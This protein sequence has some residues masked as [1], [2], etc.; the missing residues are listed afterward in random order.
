MKAEDLI[1]NNSLSN[2]TIEGYQKVVPLEI[3]I[4]AL[5]MARMEVSES[6]SLLIK[7]RNRQIEQEGFDIST[8]EYYS[9]Q[10]LAYAAVCYALPSKKRK[11]SR[12]SSSGWLPTLWP[13][14][15]NDFMWKPSKDNS[16]EGRIRELVK[17]GAL[18][19]AE[20][21]RLKKYNGIL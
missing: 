2:I 20:I 13:K 3:V 19:I 1:K 17:A 16:I 15:W 21:D 5:N 10:E 12:L 9:S 14:N 8:D 4:T 11:L 18:I 7:E 6:A